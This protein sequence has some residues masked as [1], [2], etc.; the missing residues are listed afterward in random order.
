MVVTRSALAAPRRDK[1]VKQRRSSEAIRA[2]ASATVSYN[3]QQK[4]RAGLTVQAPS[5]A[6]WSEGY[7]YDSARRLF[8]VNSPAGFNFWRLQWSVGAR[9]HLTLDP[10]PL[11]GG[12]ERE[13]G[14]GHGYPRLPRAGVSPH[15]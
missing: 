2:W 6:A 12:A 10:S 13:M 9:P 15:Y 4:L 3:Y 5:A 11:P 7:T 1:A 8:S 14:K